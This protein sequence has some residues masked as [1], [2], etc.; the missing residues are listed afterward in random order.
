MASENEFDLS[1]YLSNLITYRIERF[2][3]LL[4]SFLFWAQTW[5]KEIK[6]RAVSYGILQSRSR[7][8]AHPWGLDT[9]FLE[10]INLDLT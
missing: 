6:W 2:S 1:N 4:L 10:E 7:S 5:D 9:F 3:K 8:V